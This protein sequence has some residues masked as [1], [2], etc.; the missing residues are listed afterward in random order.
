MIS[1]KEVLAVVGT[2]GAL[3]AVSGVGVES[4]SDRNARL[5]AEVAETC[6]SIYQD[7][8][9]LHQISEKTLECMQEGW[10][11]QAGSIDTTQFGAEYH[12]GLLE[13]YVQT[14]RDRAENLDLAWPAGLGIVGVLGGCLLI[15]I[16]QNSRSSERRRRESDSEDS[17]IEVTDKTHSDDPE[18]KSPLDK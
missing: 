18:P 2:F 9:K 17:D 8:N 5:N 6:H 14:E 12:S 16:S 11:P 1:G 4:R 15:S 10:I 3:G 13:G 7:P